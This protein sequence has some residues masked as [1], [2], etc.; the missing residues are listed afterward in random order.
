MPNGELKTRGSDIPVEQFLASLPLFCDLTPEELAR[1]AAGTRRLFCEKGDSL[2]TRGDRC[3][4]FHVI[5]Y[6]Q[7]KLFVTSPQGSEKVIEIMGPGLSFGEA[8]LFMD[9]P[10]VVSAQALRDSLLLHVSRSV[11]FDE[12]ERDPRFARRLLAG[13]SRKL[14]QLVHDVEAYSLRSGL[15]RVIGYLLRED[16]EAGS[17]ALRVTLPANKMI[18]A[19]RLNL[20]PEYF[21]RILHDLEAEGLVVLEGGTI[22]VPDVE[23]LRTHGG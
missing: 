5:L 18:V 3:E 19:S 1:V 14:H 20:T 6:G 21:S 13:M 23:K 22:T 16:T 8:I 7:V 12:I 17:R 10:Y 2:F 4:G 9:M 11:V 15:E